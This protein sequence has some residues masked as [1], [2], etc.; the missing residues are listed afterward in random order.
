VNKYGKGDCG[1]TGGSWCQFVWERNE[2]QV[3]LPAA[4]ATWKPLGSWKDT[5]NRALRFGPMA[6]GYTA[7]TC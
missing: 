1:K 4:T 3:A 2:A 7:E 6:Y 5:G